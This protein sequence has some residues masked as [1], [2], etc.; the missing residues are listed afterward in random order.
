MKHLIAFLLLTPALFAADLSGIW[1]HSTKA[2]DGHTVKMALVL[3]QSGTQLSGKVKLPWGD[4]AITQGSVDGSHFTLTAKES[5]WFALTAEGALE[6]GKLHFTVHENK[7]KP[8]EVVAERTTTD[9]FVIPN[10]A[11]PPAV[12]ISHPTASPRLLRW[13]GTVGISSPAR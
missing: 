5:T 7:D 9:P 13:A 12:K 10:I 6:G 8:Y 4:V 3:T 1:F 11:P 2:A